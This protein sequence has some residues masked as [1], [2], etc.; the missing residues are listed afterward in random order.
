[1]GKVILRDV[2]FSIDKILAKDPSKTFDIEGDNFQDLKETLNNLGN[3]IAKEFE[4]SSNDVKV[5]GASFTEN[6]F[7]VF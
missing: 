3:D 5:K 1:M 4:V 7:L 2:N 6:R